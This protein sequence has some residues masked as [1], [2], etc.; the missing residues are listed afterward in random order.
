MCLKGK[1]RNEE[2]LV[3]QGRVNEGDLGE[4][5]WLIDLICLYEKEQ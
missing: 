1:I 4:G 3:G 5:L 2:V